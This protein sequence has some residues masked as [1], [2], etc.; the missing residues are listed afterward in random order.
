MCLI[1]GG[2]FAHLEA[3]T[4]GPASVPSQG[5]T[6]S[7]TVDA[8]GDGEIEG[9]KIRHIQPKELRTPFSLEAAAHG[10]PELQFLTPEQMSPADRKL[11]DENQEEIQR[12]ANL[13]GFGLR[14]GEEAGNWGYEQAVC[15]V[16]PDHIVLEYSRDNGNGDVTLFT[17]VVPRA[18]GH[19]RVIPVQ[20]RGY[21][22]FTPSPSNAITL[23]DFNHIV[24]EEG[25]GLNPDWLTLGLCYAALAGGHVRAALLADLNE[26]E[27]YPL[28]VPAK[29]MVSY[30]G[31]A[32]V[33]FADTTPHA[34]SMDWVMTFAPDGRLMKVKHTDSGELIERP[35]N[36][37]V[38]DV[39]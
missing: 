12:R 1:A 8:N 36:G 11:A 16:F 18:E 15:P 31:G 21:S 14:R 19:V 22:L 23:N 25:R 32:V 13:Q 28:F 27:H 7:G 24:K 5:Q 20:R 35:L 34:K 2:S 17:A 33:H 26:K 37:R 10:A 3:Q 39:P 29:L 6:L 38:I 9:V 4:P 30:K